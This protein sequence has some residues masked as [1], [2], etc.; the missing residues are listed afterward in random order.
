[1]LYQS[2]YYHIIDVTVIIVHGDFRKKRES[3]EMKMLE[4][5]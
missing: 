1:M 4:S 5:S 2:I 3:E